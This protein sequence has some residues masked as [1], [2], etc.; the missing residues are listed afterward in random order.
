MELPSS[1]DAL[2]FYKENKTLL[3][4]I[5]IGGEYELAYF[6]TTGDITESIVVGRFLGSFLV[7]ATLSLSQDP[8]QEGDSS[9]LGSSSEGA[10]TS[11]PS[12]LGYKNYQSMV[13]VPLPEK[14]ESVRRLLINYSNGLLNPN[15]SFVNTFTSSPWLQL[16]LGTNTI[17]K[18][19]VDST[20]K[21]ILQINSLLAPFDDYAY[22]ALTYSK[23]EDSLKEEIREALSD[24]FVLDGS[25][26]TKV[27]NASFK[28]ALIMGKDR[29]YSVNDIK[30]IHSRARVREPFEPY[31]SQKDNNIEAANLMLSEGVSLDPLAD[32]F[33]LKLKNRLF[34]WKI[35][36]EDI[37]KRVIYK[38]ALK[39]E[40]PIYIPNNEKLTVFTSDGTE[41]SLEMQDGDYFVAD[42]AKGNKRL[43]VFSDR[44]KAVVY[45]AIPEARIARLLDISK[46][47][48][49]EASSTTSS[50]IEYNVDTSTARQD[51]Y[52]LKLDKDTLVD[53]PEDSY[54]IQKTSATYDYTTVVSAIDKFV[55]HN[56]FP[57]MIIHLNNDDMF[58]NHLEETNKA[59]LT[60][61]DFTF[62]YFSTLPDQIIVRKMPQHI[63]VI[64]TDKV[65]NN[66]TQLRSTLVD[67]NTRKVTLA[68]SPIDTGR[69]GT[70]PHPYLSF[71]YDQAD[72]VNFTQDRIDNTIWQEKI[73]YEFNPSKAEAFDKY[74]GATE[75][76]PRDSRPAAK[77]FN[78]LNNI[79]TTYG[80][81]KR[82][83]IQS[84]D[85]YSRLNPYDYVG[86]F[87]DVSRDFNLIPK[88]RLN[89]ITDD[90]AFNENTFVKVKET[91]VVNEETP[92]L[93][94]SN[95][96]APIIFN[97][98]KIPTGKRVVAVEITPI[99]AG[100]AG[101]RPGGSG[102]VGDTGGGEED[103]TY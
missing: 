60:H 98:E 52:F 12:R 62:K 96:S 4:K 38:S 94:P 95:D 14:E 64:P 55:K 78:E 69:R 77:L 63:L 102:L 47:T 32:P 25:P 2:A 9:A 65:V 1:S 85:L 36:A 10:F 23:I 6:V 31:T 50:L 33:N 51:Y 68:A 88:L 16:G 40:T 80:L 100:G 99:A 37:D 58:F 39:V 76:L 21:N 27:L 82:D 66:I 56:A 103:Q 30:E 7:N 61:L 81:N 84:Y 89:E 101:E 53:E 48:S 44:S 11:S 17:F 29:D 13:P 87:L 28:L 22:N 3:N 19:V 97:K 67:F 73:K 24:V 59:K 18:D 35:L 15:Y 92:T 83:F 8:S 71:V 86:A 91:V 42:P 20:I 54:L 70:T 74:K 34:N 45:N 57:G 90:K 75:S 79:R 72:T 5:S 93:L 49:L 26:L 41:H 43:T 46:S